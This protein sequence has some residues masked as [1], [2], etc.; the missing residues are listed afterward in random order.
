M[1]GFQTKFA[2]VA[3]LAALALP[4]VA[5]AN[6]GTDHPGPPE[7]AGRCTG[8]PYELVKGSDVVA[9]EKARAEK[10]DR[11]GNGSVCR[12]DIRGEGQGNTGN[13]SNIKDDKV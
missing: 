7:E 10:A 2:A 12:K 11:N 4:G 8:R 3:V 9:A 13:N 6:R 5:S 1:R